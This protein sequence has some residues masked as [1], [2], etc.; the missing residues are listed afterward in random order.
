MVG[1]IGALIGGFLLSFY[2]DTASG[3]WWFTL[4]TAII[5]SVILLRSRLAGPEGSHQWLA[6]PSRHRRVPGSSRSIIQPA[7]PQR[8]VTVTEVSGAHQRPT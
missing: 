2:V 1:I 6:P 3:G 5:G 7:R 4:F 8:S